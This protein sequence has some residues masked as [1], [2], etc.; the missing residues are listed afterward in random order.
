VSND[1]DWGRRPCWREIIGPSPPSSAYDSDRLLRIAAIVNAHF[2]GDDGELTP[3]QSAK[4][5]LAAIADVL[6]EPW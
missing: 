4:Q 6:G 3:G 5:A 1:S 2:N